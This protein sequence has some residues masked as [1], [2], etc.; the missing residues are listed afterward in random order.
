MP[1]KILGLDIRE[2]SLAAVQ[3]ISGI[4]GFQVI[5]GAHSPIHKEGGLEQAL[6][7]ISEEMELKSDTTIVSVPNG[8]VSFRNIQMPFQD[9]KKI[10]QTLPFEM[11]TI[12][13]FPIHDVIMDFNIAERSNESQILVASLQKEHVSHYIETLKTHGIDPDIMDIQGIPT[14]NW[15]LE[16]E[17]IPDTGIFIE[18]HAKRDIMVLFLRKRMVLIRSFVSNGS[19]PP[20]NPVDINP[21]DGDPVTSDLHEI[22]LQ[23]LCKTIQNT[24]HAF[25][26]QYHMTHHPEKVFFSEIG[27]MDLDIAD[28]LSRLLG[29]P[30]ERVSIRG[31]KRVRMDDHLSRIWDPASMDRALALALRDNKKGRGFNFRRGEFEVTKRYTGLK[32][33]VRKIGVLLGLVLLFIIFDLAVDYQLLKRQYEAADQQV[34]QLYRQAFPNEKTII[35]PLDQIKIKVNQIRNSAVSFP[36][37]EAN[38]KVVDLLKDISD[39]LPATLDILITN[40]IIDQTTVRMSGETDSFNTVDSIKNILEP[41]AYFHNI[42]ISSAKMDRAGK[43]VQFEIKLE[44]TSE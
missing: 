34:L 18:I 3:V 20:S 14:A 19:V 10:K 1:G 36:G 7:D 15:L 42:V 22:G 24:V 31:D 25:G 21:T 29:I 4:K 5:A 13:P 2:D 30:A 27:T 32:K 23:S 44:R 11:E 28:R 35:R 8:C 26:W 43:R 37:V 38:Q 9:P 40:M 6:T 17:G 12:I 39:R 16:Q 41:S 33:E